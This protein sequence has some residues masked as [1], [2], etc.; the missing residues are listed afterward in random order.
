M[1]KKIQTFSYKSKGCET[2]PKKDSEETNGGC[3][4]FLT[5]HIHN[6]TLVGVTPVCGCYRLQLE[7]RM[8]AGRRAARRTQDVLSLVRF[9]AE[10]PVPSPGPSGG[11]RAGRCF[12]AHGAII[13][14][15][16]LAPRPTLPPTQPP[17]SR[18]RGWRGTLSRRGRMPPPWHRAPWSSTASSSTR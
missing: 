10:R 2:F 7:L 9:P 18:R 14:S 13:I 4:S 3:R 8:A 6:V 12:V 11:P 17:R 15:P 5:R 16:P 1:G